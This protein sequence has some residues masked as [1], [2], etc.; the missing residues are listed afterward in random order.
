MLYAST[1]RQQFHQYIAGLAS[2]Y[3]NIPEVGAK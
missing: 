1:H 3:K 2:A